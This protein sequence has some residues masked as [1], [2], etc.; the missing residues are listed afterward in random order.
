[1]D[2]TYAVCYP[3][4]QQ[5]D[6]LGMCHLPIIADAGNA[7]LCP[8]DPHHSHTSQRHPSAST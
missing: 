5:T 2:T 6:E 3:M 8:L 7:H 4:V 1:M